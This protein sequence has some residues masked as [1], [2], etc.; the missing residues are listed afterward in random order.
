MKK[1]LR[2]HEVGFGESFLR[3]DGFEAF[4]LIAN[5]GEAWGPV[6]HREATPSVHRNENPQIAEEIFF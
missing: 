5:W 1:F 6:G 2:H 3:K 4:Q